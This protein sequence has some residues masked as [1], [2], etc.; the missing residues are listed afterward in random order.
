MEA[1]VNRPVVIDSDEECST[2]YI[3]II[4]LISDLLVL[5]LSLSLSLVG[6]SKKQRRM[7][8]LSAMEMLGK[9]LERKS[10]LKQ[11]EIELRRMELEIK[12]RQLEQENEDK[13][14][15]E[16]ERK[17]RMELEFAERRALLELVQKLVS[18]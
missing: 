4:P 17:A 8:K 14:R 5:S 1:S 10:E 15:V 16:E 13:L 12:Q 3:I 6:S 11:Q 18:K 9:R 2:G 7:S